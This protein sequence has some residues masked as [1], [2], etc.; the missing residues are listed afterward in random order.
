MLHGVSW[1]KNLKLLICVWL[2]MLK[3]S[4]LQKTEV[5]E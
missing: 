4:Y 1:K 3:S 5:L 2:N